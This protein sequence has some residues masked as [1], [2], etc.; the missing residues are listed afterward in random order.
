M[1][2]IPVRNRELL[3]RLNRY[4][5]FLLRDKEAFQQN[6]HAQCQ[7]DR[8]N[9]HY[10]V[11]EKHLQEILDQGTHHEGFPDSIYGYELSVHRKDH[12]FF[13]RDANPSFRKDAT[14]E[15]SWFNKELIEWL[16]VRHNALTCFYPPGG[17]ISWHNNA[18][19]AAYNL[20]FTWSETGDGHFQ[21]VD[22]ATKK[23]VTMKDHTGW[24]CK[25]A[26][27]GHYGEPE[28]LFYH[29][30]KT[31]SWRIT[32]SFTFDTSELSAELREDLLEEI[33]SED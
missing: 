31:D 8:S 30:A 11:G 4:R 25:A 27:F 2:D 22:P 1:Q 10:W 5:D 9:R 24:Q 28:R 16:G 3:E 29:A 14:A 6:F 21:Y 13:T 32:V 18:N 12:E 26:Y 7:Q 15:L 20:I 19:A 23:I 17:Y 33:S